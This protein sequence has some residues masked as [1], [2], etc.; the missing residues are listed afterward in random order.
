MALNN[1]IMIRVETPDFA[2]DTS[3]GTDSNVTR[4]AQSPGLGGSNISSGRSRFFS[5]LSAQNA[6]PPCAIKLRA[7]LNMMDL[8]E[9]GMMVEQSL[10]NAFEN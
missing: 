6:E 7:E 2:N 3:F 9:D 1:E 10:K 4:E 5:E 8:L